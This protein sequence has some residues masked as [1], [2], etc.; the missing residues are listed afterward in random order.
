MSGILDQII[1]SQQ[2][3]PAT[4]EEYIALQLA[5]GLKDETAIARYIHYLAHHPL[6][7]LMGLFHKTKQGP[8]AAHTFHSSLTV[9][10]T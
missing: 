5:K 9:S 2:F 7:H 10:D 1:P 4:V 6:E 8:D 3:V